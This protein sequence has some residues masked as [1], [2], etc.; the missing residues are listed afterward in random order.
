MHVGAATSEGTVV[1][2][3]NRVNTEL[4]LRGEGITVGAISDS[5]DVKA[6]SAARRG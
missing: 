1:L 5:F 4:G 2:K 6:G 3:T